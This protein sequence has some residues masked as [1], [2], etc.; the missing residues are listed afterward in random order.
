MVLID[1]ISLIVRNFGNLADAD[2]RN[3]VG[4]SVTKIP[5]TS[6]VLFGQIVLVLRFD[7]NCCGILVRSINQI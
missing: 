3:L 5:S 4:D 7:K 1:S 6:L 2:R